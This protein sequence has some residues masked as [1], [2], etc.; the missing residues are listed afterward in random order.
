MSDLT[1]SSIAKL[2]AKAAAEDGLSKHHKSTIGY[3]NERVLTYLGLVTLVGLAIIWMA[4]SS[5][6]IRYGSVAVVVVIAAL[7]AILHYKRNR[8]IQ[9]L[10]EQQAKD[11]KSES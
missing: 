2:Q 5:P 8:Q 1:E 4:S 9:E 11:F 3:L 7:L 10:R 6:Y